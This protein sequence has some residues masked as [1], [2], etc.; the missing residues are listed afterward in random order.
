MPLRKNGATVLF[1]EKIPNDVPGLK[2]FKERKAKRQS[3][4]GRIMPKKDSRESKL[5]RLPKANVKIPYGKGKIMVANLA[6]MLDQA[7]VTR[8]NLADH[9]ISFIRRRSDNGYD[10]FLVNQKSHF[11][12]WVALGKPAKDAILMDPLY[13]NQIGNAAI[14]E[15]DGQTQVYLQLKPQESLILRTFANS[16]H[17]INKWSYTNAP[18]KP[19]ELKG[20]WTVEFID[21]GPTLP[22]RENL[23]KLTSWTMFDDKETSQFHGTARYTIS[24]EAP[25]GK[26]DNWILDLGKVCESARVTVN[27]RKLGTIWSEPFQICIGS[28][29]KE[30][31]NTLQID[32]TNLAANRIRDLDIN[33]VNWK[34]FHNINVVNIDYKPFD[35]SNWPVFDSGL[36]G[37]VTLTPLNNIDP[38]E[39]SRA[40]NKKPTLYIIGDSTVHNPQPGTYGLGRCNRELFCNLSN[41]CKELCPRRAQQPYIY[42]RRFMAECTG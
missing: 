38:K 12:G 1:Q 24:F 15:M 4:L 35:A 25:T 30:G 41:Q 28:Y 2:N 32:V 14:R 20:N 6:W 11:E 8:E 16:Q 42:N 3:M 9:G 18:G 23:S 31:T 10:Y 34:Y 19:I 7:S 36:I 26:A 39:I 40:L 37:P 5:D 13:E 22:A 33:K 21:G 17:P 29:L 27:G